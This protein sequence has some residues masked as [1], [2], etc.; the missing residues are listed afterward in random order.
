MTHLDHST[1]NLY[2]DDAL[3]A[4]TRSHADAHLATCELCRREL[5]ALRSLAASFDTWRPEPI[6]H[7]VTA[8]V[9]TRIAE[10]AARRAQ[11]SVLVLGAQALT[12]VALLSWALPTFLS[13][14]PLPSYTVPVIDV[15]G[16]TTLNDRFVLPLPPI[17]LWVWIPVVAGGAMLWF[18]C[19]RLIFRSLEDTSEVSQ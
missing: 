9:M 12:A 3:D 13:I 18:V 14:V 4:E 1:L 5:A 7:D 17:G 6:P 16:L 19:N 11:W 10:R 8:P 2:L 15:S